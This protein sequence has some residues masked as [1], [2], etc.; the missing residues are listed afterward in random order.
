MLAGSG[1]ITVASGLLSAKFSPR[2]QTST[3]ATGLLSAH[4]SQA[5]VN[6]IFLFS[7]S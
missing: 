1:A 4:T 7:G 3:Y 6:V 2:A 5:T